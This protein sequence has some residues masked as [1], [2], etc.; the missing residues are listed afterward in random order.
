MVDKKSFKFKTNI[1][2]TVEFRFDTPKT[3]K[4]EHGE[5]FLYGVKKDKEETAFFATPYLHDFIQSLNISKGSIAI[6]TK[7]EHDDGNRNYWT[8]QIAD[9]EYSSDDM[10]KKTPPEPPLPADKPD[11]DDLVVTIM[12]CYRGV[13]LNAERTEEKLSEEAIQKLATAIFIEASRKGVF[14]KE[15]AV[16]DITEE[17]QDDLPF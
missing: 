6:I 2:E 4:S 11:I 15:G 13:K 10:K 8:I 7:K 5:W 3:G 14:I 17:E 12:T 9:T 1:P 16:R